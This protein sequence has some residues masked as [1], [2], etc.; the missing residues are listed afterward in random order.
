MTHEDGP[1]PVGRG[2][3]LEQ[4]LH[5]LKHLILVVKLRLQGRYLLLQLLTRSSCHRLF[6]LT[7][8]LSRCQIL[9]IFSV[10]SLSLQHSLHHEHSHG[11]RTRGTWIRSPWDDAAF[12]ESVITFFRL[13]LSASSDAT[14]LCVHNS[15]YSFEV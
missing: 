14:R 2:A 13:A 11:C 4:Q 3:F 10:R 12:S 6:L 1:P 7:H 15:I 8:L 9:N 5:I